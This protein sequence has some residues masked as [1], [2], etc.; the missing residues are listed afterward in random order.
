MHVM[1]HQS[2]RRVYLCVLVTS[3]VIVVSACW[4]VTVRIGLFGAVGV[5]GGG[6][7][8]IKLCAVVVGV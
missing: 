7:M 3:V 2:G 4:V 1:R 6:W 8:G 5:Y